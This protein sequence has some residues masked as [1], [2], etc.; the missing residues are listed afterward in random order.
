MGRE[1]VWLLFSL[2]NDY[3][4]GNGQKSKW[5]ISNL[6][7]P[8]FPIFHQIFFPK[9]Y[10]S[11]YGILMTSLSFQGFP[12]PFYFPAFNIHY[13]KDVPTQLMKFSDTLSK[14]V[15]PYQNISKDTFTFQSFN[16]SQNKSNP[17]QTNQSLHKLIYR[18]SWVT[19]KYIWSLVIHIFSHDQVGHN[20]QQ[21]FKSL[22]IIY[23]MH[24]ISP[25]QLSFV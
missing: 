10:V 21:Q 8:T 13:T 2:S 11:M 1:Q 19:Y 25:S 5:V 4:T 20:L 18:I 9:R 14:L 17:F 24:K 3:L 15:K 22:Y 6:G 23:N 16:N 7:C 12:N